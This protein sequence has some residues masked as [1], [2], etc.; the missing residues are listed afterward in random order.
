MIAGPKQVAAMAQKLADMYAFLACEKLNS[1]Q[2]KEAMY[3]A[4][5]Q[6]ALD[7]LAHGVDVGKLTFP[8]MRR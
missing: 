4:E 7:A 6:K 8:A 2:V 3:L 5:W 1:G